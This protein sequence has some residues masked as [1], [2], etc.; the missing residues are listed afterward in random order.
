MPWSKPPEILTNDV[1]C[2]YCTKQGIKKKLAH[3]EHRRA[4]R[5]WYREMQDAFGL[6][7]PDKQ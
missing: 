2:P 5:K 6:P 3:E 1:Y 7:L 4:Y